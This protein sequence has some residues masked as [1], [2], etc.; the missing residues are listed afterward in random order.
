MPALGI[1]LA[2]RDFECT[3]C[4]QQFFMLSSDLISPG[5]YFCDECLRGIWE[6]EGEVL[7]KHVAER[8]TEGEEM[9]VSSVVQNIKWRKGRFSGVEVAIEQRKRTC[10]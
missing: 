2:S 8:L 6:M 1:M 5:P 3:L 7:E 4:Q 9:P 10:R